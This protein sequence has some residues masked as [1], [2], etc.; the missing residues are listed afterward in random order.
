MTSDDLPNGA[1]ID[2][3]GQLF[4]PDSPEDAL[5]FI[6]MHGAEFGGTC[7]GVE[8][9]PN[10]CTCSCYGCNYRCGGCWRYIKCES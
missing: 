7:T 1:M 10:P 5:L 3:F 4:Y 6:A 9:S 2:E 8:T